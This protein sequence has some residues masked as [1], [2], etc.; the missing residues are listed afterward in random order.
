L[1]ANFNKSK[2]NHLVIQESEELA[3]NGYRKA[4][5]LAKSHY[6][7]F[8]VVS[9]LIPANLK[10]DIA[11]IYWF[12]RTADD[13]SDEG[14]I[15]KSERLKKL[16]EFELRLKDLLQ[17]KP[18]NNFEA[19]LKNTI[20]TKK[21]NPEHFY[22]LLRAFKQDV[23]KNRYENF[24]EVLNYCSNSANPVGRILLELFNI[25]SEEAFYYSDKICTALQITNFIQDT[26]I[27]YQ[28]D[29]IY[30]PFDEMEKFEVDEKVFEMKGNNLNLKKLIEFSVNRVQQFFND[31]KPL[32]KFLSG[33]FR[34]EIAWT[35]KGGEEILN[36]IRGA[37]FDIFS[38]RPS[39][40]KIDYL[41]L[42]F[43][44]IMIH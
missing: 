20:I 22:N 2:E 11:I 15:S 7:N 6:E 28:K 5:Q 33:R 17:N 44:S 40:T 19:A 31:G 16:D 8:P 12:A 42:F 35:I 21:L 30:F 41:K 29:Q 18:M 34:Y 27:D 39:L 37:D 24:D 23:V 1:R 26:E 43:K 14:N 9:W 13:Y 36:K 3:E 25:H 32:L 10:N 4:L 38:K